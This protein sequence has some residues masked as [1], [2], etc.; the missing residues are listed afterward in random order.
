MFLQKFLP[1][2]HLINFIIYV[3]LQPKRCWVI[4]V[5]IERWKEREREREK[6]L[7]T[8]LIKIFFLVFY[9]NSQSPCSKTRMEYF[10][11]KIRQLIREIC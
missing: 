3:I 7:A 6:I 11:I 4:D 10:N 1:Q 9:V 5:Y 8:F 2:K